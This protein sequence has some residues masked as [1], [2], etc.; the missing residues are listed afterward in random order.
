MFNASFVF[1]RAH[2]YFFSFILRSSIVLVGVLFDLFFSLLAFFPFVR[3]E[4]K[5]R[6]KEAHRF[7]S[8]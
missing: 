5:N 3:F 8:D 2:A 6:T 7:I 4:N 1:V